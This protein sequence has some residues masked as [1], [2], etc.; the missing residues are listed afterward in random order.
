MEVAPAEIPIGWPIP[1]AQT[2]VLDRFGQPVPI[3]VKGELFI[4][5]H[6]L[7][8]GYLSHPELTADRFLPHP[9]AADAGARI[10]RTGVWFR[11]LPDGNLEFLGRLDDQV[12][13]RG[14]RIELAEI[15]KVLTRIVSRRSQAVVLARE[16]RPGDKRLVGLYVRLPADRVR[17]IVA[18]QGTSFS[19]MAAWVHD[20]SALVILDEL[21]LTVSGKVDWLA[22]PAPAAGSI[23][24]KPLLDAPASPVEQLLAE[25]WSQVLAVRQ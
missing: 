24:Q 1:N 11:Y 7:A 12:K 23:E 6:G 13:I 9:F 15:E 20:L 10:Y 3:G 14:F 5:G 22:L 4:G 25:I 16:D 18:D 19:K 21:P 17:W 8:R 2:Y